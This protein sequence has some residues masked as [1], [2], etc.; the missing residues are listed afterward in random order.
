MAACASQP[1][2][3]VQLL[4]ERG[5]SATQEAAPS[6]LLGQ[7]TL[8]SRLGLSRNSPIKVAATR[9]EVLQL[10]L[11]AGA[12]VDAHLVVYAVEVWCDDIATFLA[13]DCVSD[14]DISEGGHV[15]FQI[16]SHIQASLQQILEMG[17]NINVAETCGKSLALMP[18]V[19]LTVSTRV[20][21]CA[22][23]VYGRCLLLQ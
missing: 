14:I 11:A 2:P 12:T 1:I 15:D 21:A 8:C 4:L 3:I 23:F 22:K 16:V 9:P 6:S 20:C 10:L 13:R 5:T 17:G 19:V 7:G 18:C